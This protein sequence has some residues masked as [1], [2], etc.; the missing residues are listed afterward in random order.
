MD[1]IGATQGEDSWDRAAAP[2]R[3][4]TDSF[5][6]PRSCPLR[7]PAFSDRRTPHLG[8]SR[9]LGSHGAGT[10]VILF[11]SDLATITNHGDVPER[12]TLLEPT[13]SLASAAGAGC[14]IRDSRG[15][16]ATR[17]A[18]GASRLHRQ[19]LQKSARRSAPETGDRPS[20]TY[21]EGGR[22]V[23]GASAGQG[24]TSTIANDDRNG[25]ETR[26]RTRR[27]QHLGLSRPCRRCR[28]RRLHGS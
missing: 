12:I 27:P 5:A 7:H 4:T 10:Y 17:P 1:R 26:A 2:P 22:R 23:S 14:G 18:S 20:W 11:G 9:N 8:G 28:S 15:I 25:G 6:A 24:R 16:R 19:S 3:R 13:A 21:G